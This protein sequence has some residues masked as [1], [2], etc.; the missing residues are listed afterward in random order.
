VTGN[1]GNSAFEGN[2]GVGLIYTDG[3][4]SISGFGSTTL[5]TIN[6]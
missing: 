2:G 5:V 6:P 1:G 4:D 3:L